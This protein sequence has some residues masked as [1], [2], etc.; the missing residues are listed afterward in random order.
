MLRRHLAASRDFSFLRS[1]LLLTERQRG[2][3]RL[4]HRFPRVHPAGGQLSSHTH[5]VWES[6]RPLSHIASFLPSCVFAH[7]HVQHVYMYVHLCLFSQLPPLLTHPLCPEQGFIHLVDCEPSFTEWLN[8]PS[9]DPDCL[10]TEAT[11]RMHRGSGRK[12]WPGRWV[13][14]LKILVTSKN[15]IW[16][17]KMKPCAGPR[18]YFIVKSESYKPKF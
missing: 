7:I 17:K 5:P 15:A 11:P 6:N 3:V 4:A 2:R 18:F 13:A 10:G 14:G 9:L 12:L 16:I 8:L 1:E